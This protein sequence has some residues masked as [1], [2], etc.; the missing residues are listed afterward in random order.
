MPGSRLVKGTMILSIAIFLSKMLGLIFVIPFN[1]LVGD[2]GGAL[3]G[4]AY[5]PYTILLSIATLGV[6]LAVSKFVSKYNA[7]GDYHTGRRLFRSGLVLMTL[8]G[9]L[10]F[11]S[12]YFLA[13]HL[14]PYFIEKSDDGNTIQDV[15]LVMRMVSIALIIIPSM[16]LIRGYFQGF[17]SMGPTAVSQLVEQIVRIGFILVG[18]YIVRTLLDGSVTYAVSVATFG[19]FVGGLASL[20]VLII[21]W[22]KRKRHLD[23]Q[24]SEST[25]NYNIPLR[26]MYKELIAYAVPFVAVG[27]A[28]SLYQLVDQF[29]VNYYL[30]SYQHFKFSDAEAVF[31]NLNFYV[32]K[33]IMIPV[34]LST[35]IALTVVPMITRSFAENKPQA[36][37]RDITQSLQLVAFLTIPAALGLSILGYM[38]YGMLY[39]V[40]DTE[41]LL[42]GGH[43]LRWYAPSSILF[44][45]FSVTAAILQGINKQKITVFSLGVGLLLKMILNPLCIRYFSTMGPIIATNIGYLA[46][47]LINLWT[48]NVFTGYRYGFIAKRSLLITL[49][50][51]IMIVIIQIL[52]WL[53]GG[54]VPTHYVQAVI[55]SFIGVIIGG[56]AFIILSLRSGLANQVFGDRLPFLKRR[57]GQV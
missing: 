7:L 33:L 37:Q 51:S 16:S 39:G 49:F 17:E 54:G 28:M 46:S 5:V 45:L 6:P 26:A 2:K 35:A 12:L 1:A 11:I 22:I 15:T 3:Y 13:P 14:A 38:L 56:G 25:K 57:K 23:K 27:L 47:V 55:Y 50:A 21:Y 29:T 8:T 34:S 30:V 42:L 19:A 48:I 52:L 9:V 44:A 36:L 43:I 32:Q 31:A 4:Y 24:L 41:K 20:A 40:G 53:T 10:S 18:A